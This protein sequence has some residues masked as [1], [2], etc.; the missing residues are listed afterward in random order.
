[1]IA[2]VHDEQTAD[3]KIIIMRILFLLL[4]VCVFTS[5]ARNYE[6]SVV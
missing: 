1:M 6:T 2:V 5:I 3:I 4:D